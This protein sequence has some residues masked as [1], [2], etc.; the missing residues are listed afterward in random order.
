[1]KTFKE[2]KEFCENKIKEFPEFKT[3]YKKEISSLDRFFKNG[4][5]IIEEFEQKKDKIDNRYVIPFLLGYTDEVDLSK[6]L[7][8]IQVSPGASGGRN[9][10]Y[11]TLNGNIV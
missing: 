6:P 11:A 7:D 2:I 4:R 1:M 10:I 3:R 8:M 5:N 9:K